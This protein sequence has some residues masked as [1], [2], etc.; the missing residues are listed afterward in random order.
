MLREAIG[1]IAELTKNATVAK[2]IDLSLN[3]PAVS[4]VYNA[5]DGKI[6]EYDRKPPNRGHTLSTIASFA[7]AYKRYAEMANA[8][9]WVSLKSVV[10][11][12]NDGEDQFRQN[13]LT[14]PVA[15][16]PLFGTVGG[17]PVDQEQLLQAIRHDLKPA[18]I[19]PDTFE[20]AI[21]NLKW[22][23]T[24]TAEGS[25]G[26]VKSSMG[27]QINAEVKGEKDIPAEIEVTFEPFPELT[28]EF[29]QYGVRSTVQVD[30]S[31]HMVP[32]EREIIVQPYPGQIGMAQADAV[33][34]LRRVI[35]EAVGDDVSASHVFAGTP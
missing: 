15:V 34:L 17:L 14:I 25:Y 20:L 12:I 32:A 11:I 2:T 5:A 28:K 30:C 29:Q 26:T 24:D 7:D 3:N 6:V 31:V 19:T 10:C 13:R 8:S 21:A 22:Q 9:V 27:R 1:T 35:S 18:Q 23:T 33:E 16:S 4:H